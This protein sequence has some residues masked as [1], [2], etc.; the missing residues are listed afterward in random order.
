IV[1]IDGSAGAVQASAL[2]FANNGYVMR[3][4]ALTLTRGAAPAGPVEVRVGDG[5]GASSGYTATVNN[6]LAG[7]DGLAKTGAGNLVLTRA[8]T[9]SGGTWIRDGVLSVGADDNLGAA[10][11]TVTLDGGTLSVTGSG[12]SATPR[13]IA[14]GASGGSFD[15]AQA[16]HRFVVANALTG[17]G[18]LVKRGVGTLVLNGAH[19]HT[20]GT[21]IEAGTLVVA[22]NGA[23]G[24]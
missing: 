6:V 14:L 11:A 17:P 19:G 4:D 24:T 8:N 12:F 9:Y 20:G 3:G 5:G 16:G 13:T 10:G 1:T 21:S 18:S 23:L 7:T 15:I 22:R 2:Q